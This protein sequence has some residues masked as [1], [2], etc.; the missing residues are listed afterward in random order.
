MRILLIEDEEGLGEALQYML[1]KNN[2][3]TDWVTD[4]IDG[5]DMAESNIYDLIIL[6]R[7]LPR[8][9]GVEILK[10][11]RKKGIKT[12]VIFLTARDSIDAR[13]E[14]LDAGADDYLIKPF[15]VDELL[16]R[17][18]V[19]ARRHENV[20]E[21]NKIMLGKLVIDNTVCEVSYETT[22]IK[23]TVKE[24]QLLELLVRNHGKVMTKEQILVRVWGAD[25]E[26]EFNSIELYI[27]YLRKKIDFKKAGVELKTI[28]GIGY[29]LKEV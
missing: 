16:A 12:T 26:V 28:R 9:E 21:N 27:Y 13:V 6:D 17:I 15:A 11:L 23:L 8:K 24:F 14:G 29:C 5:Q 4:G 2:Y 19:L 3:L 22:T 10:Y 18:R 7:M 25:S 1:Q 20:D